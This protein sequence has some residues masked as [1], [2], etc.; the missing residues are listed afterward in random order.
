[1]AEQGERARSK[2]DIPVTGMSCASCVARVEKALAKQE[3]VS[4]ASVNFAAEKAS[5]AYDP[6]ETDTGSLIG[7]I[8]DAGYGTDV[9]EVSFSVTGMS[10]ASCVGRVERAVQKVPGVLSAS[11]NLASE[12]AVVEYLAGE[13][14][15]RQ[16]ERAIEGAG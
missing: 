4:Q 12:K 7:A 6:E 11:V 8:E 10:C 14:D 13:A 15:P 5:I 1:M 3:G 2:V 9:R 16:I